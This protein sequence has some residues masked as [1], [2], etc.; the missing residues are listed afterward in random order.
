MFSA[1]ISAV[2]TSWTYTRRW[3]PRACNLHGACGVFLDVYRN[4]RTATCSVFYGAWT[5]LLYYNYQLCA[6]KKIA[7]MEH[8]T[9]IRV[10]L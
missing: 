4:A 1:I 7:Y 8:A 6:S 2:Y 9:A 3:P 5:Q 10:P